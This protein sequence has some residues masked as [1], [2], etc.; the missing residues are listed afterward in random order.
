MLSILLLFNP[1][2]AAL[3]KKKKKEE[4]VNKAC[5]RSDR[6]AISLCRQII[7]GSQ[8]THYLTRPVTRQLHF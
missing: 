8:L 5:K 6:F 4:A 3:D 1:T 7:T 2:I